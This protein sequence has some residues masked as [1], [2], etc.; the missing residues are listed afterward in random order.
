MRTIWFRVIGGALLLLVGVVWVLQGSGATGATGGMNGQSEWT[1]IG[2]VVAVVGV[3][4][5]VGGITRLRAAK[6]R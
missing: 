1:L 2:M 4:L 3:V 5:L 6:R